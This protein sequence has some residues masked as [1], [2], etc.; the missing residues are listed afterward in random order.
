MARSSQEARSLQ[1]TLPPNAGRG[2]RAD[3]DREIVQVGRGR[4]AQVH[5]YAR[6]IEYMRICEYTQSTRPKSTDRI[7]GF[8][9]HRAQVNE[10]NR[11]MKV[12]EKGRSPEE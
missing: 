6:I 4:D 8:Q 3:R 5:R 10:S 12:D 7:D 2:G 11:W 1:C 9:I